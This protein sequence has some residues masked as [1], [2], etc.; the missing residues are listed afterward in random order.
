MT[1]ANYLKLGQLTFLLSFAFGSILFVSYLITG[2]DNL[3]I[4]GYG[5]VAITGLFNLAIVFL[6]VQRAQIDREN[7]KALYKRTALLFVN[8]PILLLYTWVV[9]YL[10]GTMRITLVNATASPL[11]NI[12]LVGCGGAALKELAP[13]QQKTLWV[14]ITGDCSIDLV[15]TLQ[16][17]EKRATI[18]GYATSGM[19]G[20]M[21]YVVE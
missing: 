6:L 14:D 1:T 20:K 13:Q 15:Y 16:G 21:T 3:L 9:L 18:V 4:T 11:S 7:S 8:L 2:W 17:E 19:G 10:L 5:Y 12:Q